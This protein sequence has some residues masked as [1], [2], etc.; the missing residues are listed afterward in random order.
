MHQCCSGMKRI[1]SHISD[2]IVTFYE[3]LNL[4]I[5][6]EIREERESTFSSGSDGLRVSARQMA[7]L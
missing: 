1:E 2:D 6:L 5:R 7:S 3:L 4:E